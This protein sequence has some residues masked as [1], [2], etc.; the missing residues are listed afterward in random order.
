MLGPMLGIRTTVQQIL[1]ANHMP[2]IVLL[3]VVVVGVNKEW[4][5]T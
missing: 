3:V 4:L 2:I 1:G 5:R